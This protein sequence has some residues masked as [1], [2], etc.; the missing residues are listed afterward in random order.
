MVHS[1]TRQI[2][3]TQINIVPHIHI[4]GETRDTHLHELGST[5]HRANI[6]P[7]NGATERWRPNIDNR[8]HNFYSR[9]LELS[10]ILREGFTIS[11]NTHT[12]AFSLFK[13]IYCNMSTYLQCLAAHLACLNSVFNVAAS[14]H[15]QPGEG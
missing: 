9:T 7:A 12:R 6:R 4:S 15:F 2:L 11:E 10:M 8:I 3:M 5:T 14:E 1:E 13:T